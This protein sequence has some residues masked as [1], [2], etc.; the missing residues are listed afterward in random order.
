[1]NRPPAGVRRGGA[2]LVTLLLLA[3][4]LG[5]YSQTDLVIYDDALQNGWQDW[6]W[7]AIDY[8]QSALV[9]S[10]A[11]AV[12]VTLTN[13]EWQAIYMHHGAMSTEPYTALSFWIHGGP[14]GGQELQVKALTHGSSLAGVSLPAL[15]AARWQQV[16]LPLSDLGVADTPDLTGF[17]IQDRVGSAKPAFYLDE[18]RLNGAPAITNLPVSIRVDPLLDRRPINPMI[19]GVAFASA[20]EL[21]ALN[22]PLNRSGGNAETRYNWQI[23]AHNRA[24]D[25]Y[26]E[27]I[28]D[29]P[30]TPGAEGDEHVLAS[31]SGGAE[32]L[33]TVSM[34]G[35]MPKLGPSRAKQASYSIAKYGPQLDNDWQWFSDAGNGVSVTNG[36][37]ITWNDPNDANFPTNSVFQQEWIRHLT[38]VWGASTNGGVRYYCMD[39]EH[40][41]W[42]STHQDIHPVGATMQEVRDRF[43]DYGERIK[44]VDPDALLFAPEEWGWIGYFYSGYDA[45]WAAENGWNPA[46]FPD[47]GAH[48][49][50]DYLPWLLDQARQYELN[51][52]RRL[53]DVFTLHYYPQ[54]GETGNDVSVS[55]QLQRNRGTRVL[56]D[57][58]YVDSSW[59]NAV[60]KLIPRMKGW[61]E[62]YYPGT[63][64]GITEYNWGAED[65]INGAT[66]QAD[67]LGI[68]GREG[69]DYATRWTTPHAGTP[70]FK[71]MKMYRNYDG[72]RSTFGDVSVS[73]TGPNPDDLSTFAAVRSADN[74]LTLMVIN[75]HLT[76]MAPA[77]LTLTNFPS[78]G[79]VQ[80]W[81][82]TSA[83]AIVRLN[84]LGLQD[85]VFNSTLPPQSLT[86]FVV[87]G[88]VPPRLRDAR[89]KPAGLFEFWLEG[90][91]NQRYAIQASADLVGWQSVQTNLLSS[92]PFR[93]TLQV[94][95]DRR[96]Y[97]ARVLP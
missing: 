95:A 17:W 80:A 71:A 21:E 34:I 5:L 76:A 88:E 18:V 58:S 3:Q 79:P 60:V 16:T 23:N 7:T 40:T 94:A 29:S 64:I 44:E 20:S 10:G 4:T 53:L 65:H 1:M 96:Y 55:M 51:N 24:R 39:N 61:V 66:A 31:K 77:T 92:N 22:A 45:Q 73:A 38:N 2:G 43:F 93:V 90:Q 75:K 19:Y 68:F 57:A 63:P 13:A 52:G 85:G 72:N 36:T 25:W 78:V 87:P 46:N 6:G 67:I 8:S 48:G 69:L 26:F 33:L 56:W 91:V 50:W 28:A 62:A 59:I 49:G 14:T 54:Q 15:P 89:A 83:N 30:A 86:L 97:R 32:P 74:A 81:Q 35:W 27:S 12:S 42:H 47:R 82:L 41:L 11:H 9:Y 70:T 37:P 84:D